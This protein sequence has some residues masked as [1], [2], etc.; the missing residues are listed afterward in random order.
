MKIFNANFD[1]ALG[2]WLLIS[3]F[4]PFCMKDKKDQGVD[5][6]GWKAFKRR[7]L[8]AYGDNSYQA[9]TPQSKLI[10]ENQNLYRKI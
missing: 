9:T 5:E 2:M 8:A 3:L 1:V 10:S 4:P 6:E 7:L